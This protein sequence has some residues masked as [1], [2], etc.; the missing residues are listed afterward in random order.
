[1]RAEFDE[2]VR[3]DV[4]RLRELVGDDLEEWDP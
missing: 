1:V 2:R 3:D 4:A